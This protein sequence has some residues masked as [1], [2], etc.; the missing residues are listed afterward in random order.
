MSD[1]AQKLIDEAMAYGAH[2][3]SPLD[4][5]IERAEGIYVWDVDGKKYVDCLSAYSALNQGHCHPKIVQA[6]KDQA[7]KLAL[8]SRAFHNNLMGPFMHQLC[9]YTGFEQ[10][11]LMNSGAEAV[12]TA[13]KLAR[14]WGY[15]K[16][17]IPADKAEIIVCEN[18]FHGR[19]TTIVNF[20]T[21]KET[22]EHFGPGTPGFKIIPFNDVKALQEAINDN[23]AA[24]L[25][26]PIQGEGGI[27]VPD[28]G[29]LAACKK[30]CQDN[31]V[32]LMFDEIQT[33]FGRTGKK[34]CWQHENVKPDV[35]TVGK[36]LSGGMYPISAALASRKIM[37]VFT[38]Y[39][40]GSTF[41][42]NPLAAAVDMASLD[43]LEEE[44][45]HEKAAES[46]AYALQELR[47]VKCPIIKEV[48]GKG[49]LIGIEIN[50]EFGKAAHFTEKLKEQGILL[51]G[52]H[53]TVL[54]LA[55]P[56][57]ITKPELKET[58]DKIV[59]VLEEACT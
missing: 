36:A 55:P 59:N 4:V 16:K 14:K 51:K 19:T 11:L 20:S 39:T 22:Y 37:S 38:P 18:N 49:L 7:S 43:V 34:F 54:R 56:L 45:L 17:G 28:E 58:I 24:F 8:T 47:K 12:E 5:V 41:G 40:H 1:K 32:L 10:C 23:T 9:D 33:G 52:T 13:L 2:N 26:E 29:Y 30:L 27:I 44:K 3:Y 21:E 42:G 46:G 53:D 57:I 48:R 6:L 50:P 15:E 31:N 35:M 25:V